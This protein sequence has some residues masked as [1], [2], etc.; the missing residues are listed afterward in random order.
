MGTAARPNDAGAHVD[1]PLTV[2]QAS[3]WLLPALLV[4]AG[5]MVYAERATAAPPDP[6]F[7]ISPSMPVVGETI[8]FT[9]TSTDDVAVVRQLWDL[10]DD[11]F[12]DD[13]VEPTATGG[14]LV[15]G[16]YTVW[17]RVFDNQTF[18]TTSKTVTV[19]PS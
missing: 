7:T 9:S 11:G 14:F 16:Q 10:N 3:R 4:L 8:T 5:A 12:F 19:V 18:R 13:G 15:D 2:Q 1:P 17:L 6:R